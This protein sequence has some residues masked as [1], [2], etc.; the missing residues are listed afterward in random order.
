MSRY[1]P[2][3]RY[4]KETKEF[5]DSFRSIADAADC[6][7]VDESSIRKVLDNENRTCR[8]Y[9][10]STVADD[11]FPVNEV[12]KKLTGSAKVIQKLR[13]K[14]R[15]KDNDFRKFARIENSITEI[16]EEIVKNF[17]EVNWNIAVK[18]YSKIE[19]N[20]KNIM[21]VQLS[22]LHL[23]E[24]IENHD[25]YSYNINVASARLKKFAEYIRQQVYAW[26]P[27]IILVAMTGDMI[28]S[29]KRLDNI[30]AKATSRAKASLLATKLIGQFLLEISSM[31]PVRVISVVG[32]ESRMS[33]DMGY[34]DRVISDNYDYIIY[35]QLRL[36]LEGKN[37][38]IK[39]LNKG[40]EVEYVMS[41]NGHNILFSHGF[42][43]KSKDSQAAMQSV[44]GKYGAIGVPINF[45]IFGHIHFSNITDLYARS[46][47]L[48]GGNP[49]SDRALNLAGS[50][51]QNIHIVDDSIHS[52]K[53]NLEKYDI[54][55]FY[56]IEELSG[57]YQTDYS[58]RAVYSDKRQY[59]VIPLE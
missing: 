42:S 3:Y 46:S 7:D 24:L 9:L 57:M 26:S 41:I 54:D 53:V 11:D 1:I 12:S 32:N 15:M 21:I 28:S 34:T 8:G 25:K 59:I 27:S 6:F 29:D 17:D 5:V 33:H 52:M 22:D 58:D 49:Y 38:G 20:G 31:A 45:I 2:V 55:K 13:D 14:E 23:D 51:A 43:Y 40:D 48:M 16:G 37:D 50:A 39:F 56:T 18:D 36:L 19:N 35:N 47:S 4:N 30:L 10:W 44:I